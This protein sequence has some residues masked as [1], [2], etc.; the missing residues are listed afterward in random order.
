MIAWIQQSHSTTLTNQGIFQA[1][2]FR[3]KCA[4]KEYLPYEKRVFLLLILI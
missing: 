1:H 3:A 2:A 4:K